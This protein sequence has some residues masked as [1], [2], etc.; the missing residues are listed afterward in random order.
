[1]VSAAFSI[2]ALLLSSL[3]LYGLLA[4]TVT[5]RTSEIGIRMALGARSVE[6]LRMIMA[7]GL[8]LVAL[9][10]GLGLTAAFALSRFL[11]SLLFGV[12]THD[13][14]TFAGVAALLAIVSA[15]AVVIPARRATMVNPMVALRKD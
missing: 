5:D 7:D 4:Y 9:G 1:V 15:F 11:E 2:T 10:A 3:G 6:V 8:R 13:P 14:A 12:T